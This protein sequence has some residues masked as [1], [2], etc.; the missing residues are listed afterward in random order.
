MAGDVGGR[1]P[2]YPAAPGSC[3]RRRA[4]PDR[5][6]QT[7]VFR[8]ARRR[9]RPSAGRAVRGNAASPGG[10]PPHALPGAAGQSP[11]A[12]QPA[13]GPLPI[14]IHVGSLP[15]PAEEA[16][17][18][19]CDADPVRRSAD[20]PPRPAPGQGGAAA[21]HQAPAP[22]ATGAADTAAAPGPPR[23]PG[24]VCPLPRRGRLGYRPHGSGRP[25]T[26]G[27]QQRLRQTAP[28]RG[29]EAPRGIRGAT[30]EAPQRLDGGPAMTGGHAW[31]RVLATGFLLDVVALVLLVL[32]DNVNLF[33]T[34][35]LVG[36]FLVPVTY[37]VF[38]YE[39][40]FLSDLPPPTTGVTFV[41]GGLL[42]V[43]AAGLL[44][45]LLLSGLDVFTVLEIGLI[46]EFAKILGVVAIAGHQRH[47]EE[48]DGLILG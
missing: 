42:G 17:R 36:N 39:R 34:V 25:A 23:G 31:W 29:Q 1:P 5:R 28:H 27:A 3:R 44:E 11:V 45:P 35:V 33:P 12:P 47:H 30:G 21:G 18:A 24:V 10:R 9:G 20:R 41:Y 16:L 4:A 2:P 19:L 40:R 43:L 22:G 14:R 7:A 26:L 37:V 46:E 38:F 32:T 48:M 8:E 15:A 13:P 6:R